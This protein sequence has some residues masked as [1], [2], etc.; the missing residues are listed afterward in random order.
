MSEKI[1]NIIVNNKKLNIK[2]KNAS[3]YDGHTY[4][5]IYDNEN[6]RYV[7]EIQDLYLDDRCFK[8]KLKDFLKLNY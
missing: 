5:I 7:G 2:C 3:G 8:T 1:V 4:T 6:G